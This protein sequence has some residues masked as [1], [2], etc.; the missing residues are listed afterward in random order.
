[1]AA[2]T[3]AS[4]HKD[5]RRSVRRIALRNRKCCLQQK[6]KVLKERDCVCVCKEE[7]GGERRERVL[8]GGRTL[9]VQCASSELRSNQA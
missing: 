4:G 9:K 6:F 2:A 8:R 3:A 1:M 7:R 5:A